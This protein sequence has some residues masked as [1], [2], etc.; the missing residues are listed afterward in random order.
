MNIDLIAGN[1]VS[2]CIAHDAPL[3]GNP[4]WVRYE[5][6]Q[7]RLSIVFE[8]GVAKEI[9]KP[10]NEQVDQHLKSARKIMLVRLNGGRPIEGYECRL[11]KF[12]AKG[13]ELASA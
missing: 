7:H 12:D 13:N 5:T 8:D 2:P 6:E 4:L 3:E 11:R 1:R 9:E 10:V